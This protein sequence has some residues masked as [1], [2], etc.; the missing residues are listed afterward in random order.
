VLEVAVHDPS[1]PSPEQL[2]HTASSV[3]FLP[4]S[5]HILVNIW[6]ESISPTSGMRSGS[7]SLPPGLRIRHNKMIEQPRSM[8]HQFSYRHQTLVRAR[9][10]FLFQQALRE[11]LLDHLLYDETPILASMRVGRFQ[12]MPRLRSAPVK[13]RLCCTFNDGNLY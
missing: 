12:T 2:Q 4:Q 10:T 3:E 7:L 13:F 8:I 1:S 9:I 11:D 6:I 5:E